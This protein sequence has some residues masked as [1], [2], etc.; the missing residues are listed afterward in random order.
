MH[1]FAHR[2]LTRANLRLLLLPLFALGLAPF[3]SAVTYCVDTSSELNSA[4]IAAGASASDD[5][6]RLE[7]GSYTLGEVNLAVFGAL[8]LRGGY[9]DTCSGFGSLASNSTI[10]T[11]SNLDFSLSTRFGNLRIDRLVFSAWRQVWVTDALSDAG[12]VGDFRISRSRFNNQVRGLFITTRRFDVRVENS[13]FDAF[14]NDGLRIQSIV[15]GDSDINVLV[16]YNTIVNPIGADSNTAGLL[17]DSRSNTFAGVGVFNNVINGNPI[18]LKLLG[19][20]ARVRR[21]FWNTQEFGSGGG[22]DVSSASNLFG[23]PGL[24][25]SP[26]FR[27]IVPTSQLI[28][29][30]STAFSDTPSFDYS[31]G[32]R[33]IGTRPDIGAFETSLDNSA[34]I[35]VTS[36][37][38]SGAGSLR[39]AITSANTNPGF[40]KITFNIPGGCPQQINLSTTLPAIT[41]LVG[42]E[43]YTQPGSVFNTTPQSF[44][45][46]VCVFLVGGNNISSGL[47]LQTQ[48]ADAEMTVRGLGFYGFSSEALRIS[49][50]GKGSVRGNVFATGLGLNGLGQNFSDAVIRVIDAPGTQIGTLENAD[51]NVIGGGDVVGLDLTA[52]VLGKRNVE[53]NL[54]GINRNGT[55]GLPNGIGVRITDSDSDNVS[56]N[57]ISFNTSHAV[58]INGTATRSFVIFNRIGASLDSNS[59]SGNGGNAVRILAGSGHRVRLNR[60][61]KSAS[62]GIVVLTS[63]RASTLRTNYFDGNQRQAINLSPD[64]VN[65]IDLD[66][67]QTGANDQQNY[68]LIT[69]AVGSNAQGEVVLNFSSANGLYSIELYANPDCFPSVGGFNQAQKF[70]TAVDLISLAC[71][72]ATSNC[73]G[74]LRIPVT[75]QLLFNDLLIG[76]GITALAIDEEGNTSEISA[77]KL[78]RQGDN[79]FKNGFE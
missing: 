32:P 2:N 64:G 4:L 57:L 69:D 18:D 46:T 42:I 58:T 72:T 17:L 23:D 48:S 70:L 27:P 34:S 7:T 22:L 20:L 16:H 76:A 11:S 61:S 13:I 62:D 74:Q 21:N 3:A 5:E 71:A 78:Y 54:I 73:T 36:N 63:A 10:T 6:I 75:N 15:N 53:G 39:S 19:Q 68:P 35:V 67:G 56:E 49:G 1:A 51:M 60:I 77:C 79:L 66:V 14:S 50:P 44:D 33:L 55:T 37:A 59:A 24:T 25:A 9:P 52:S 38:D 31:A 12:A 40:K 28:N 65:P 30:G 26:N 8:T 43:G 47:R 41:Q 29:N 45:G